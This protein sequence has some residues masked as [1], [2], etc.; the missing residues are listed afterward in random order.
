MKRAIFRQMKN[1]SSALMR[2]KEATQ[3]GRS[4]HSAGST[5][6]SM[7]SYSNPTAGEKC[8]SAST[9]KEPILVLVS[10][11]TTCQGLK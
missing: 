5:D 1:L 9:S 8:K 3:T 4:Q 7:V 2:R 11:Q 6:D 10:Q